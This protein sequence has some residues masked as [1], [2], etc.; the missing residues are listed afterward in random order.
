MDNIKTARHVIIRISY[1]FI[2]TD[3]PRTVKHCLSLYRI[4][5]GSTFSGSSPNNGSISHP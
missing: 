4:G 5:L 2:E 1:L 3:V